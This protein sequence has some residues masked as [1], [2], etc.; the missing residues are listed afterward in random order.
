MSKTLLQL[1]TK[2]EK[3]LKKIVL[4]IGREQG[5]IRLSTYSRG[6]NIRFIDKALFPTAKCLVCRKGLLDRKHVDEHRKTCSYDLKDYDKLMK[7]L[8]E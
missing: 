8:K 4:S 6:T 5:I 3:S 7:D 2:T 1:A